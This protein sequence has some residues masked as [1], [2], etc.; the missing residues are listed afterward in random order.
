LTGALFLHAQP[1]IVRMT[2]V[3]ALIIAAASKEAR[4]QE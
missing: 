2:I 3:C 4:A 1:L